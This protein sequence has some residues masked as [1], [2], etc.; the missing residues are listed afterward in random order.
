LDQFKP[1]WPEIYSSEF[2][3][4]IHSAKL[5]LSADLLITLIEMYHP[6]AV[7]FHGIRFNDTVRHP[8]SPNGRDLRKEPQAVM[9]AKALTTVLKA[10][11]RMA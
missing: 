4:G 3:K 6:L 2:L 8:G 5:K 9:K 7:S 1:K 11:F 10:R